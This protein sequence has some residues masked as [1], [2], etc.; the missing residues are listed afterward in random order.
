MSSL[1]YNGVDIGYLSTKE[2]VYED[3]M[4]EDG[5]D[6]LCTK[7]TIHVQGHLLADPASSIPAAT[8]WVNAQQLLEQPRCALLFQT[9]AV[10]IAADDTTDVKNGPFPQITSI[11]RIDGINAIHVGFTVVTYRCEVVPADGYISNR[12][13]DEETRDNQWL[14]RTKR[15]GTV[16]VLG[17]AGH[18]SPDDFRDA[19]TPPVAINFVR[20]RAVFALQSDGLAMTYTIEDREVMQTPPSPTVSA[21]GEFIETQTLPGAYRTGQANVRLLGSKITPTNAMILQAVSLAI[22]RLQSAGMNVVNGRFSAELSVKHRYMANG[23]DVSA[24]AMLRNYAKGLTANGSNSNYDHYSRLPW[25]TDNGLPDFPLRSEGSANSYAPPNSAS[26]P[27]FVQRLAQQVRGNVTPNA[28]AMANA[29]TYFVAR[30]ATIPT[31]ESLFISGGIYTHYEVRP[32]Y[33]SR[34]GIVELPGTADGADIAFCH[35]SQPTLRL[36]LEWAAERI[37]EPPAIPSSDLQADAGPVLLKSELMPGMIETMPGGAY[38][39][40]VA[41]SYEFGFKKPALV[42]MQAAVAPWAAD[43]E[44]ADGAIPIGDLFVNHA[45]RQALNDQVNTIF[46]VGD[47]TPIQAPAVAP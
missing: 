1:K 22:Q 42:K 4:S 38:R 24:R 18:T 13:R 30:V 25:P 45:A 3:Q 14:A 26:S 6:Y 36:V 44:R 12:W 20:E 23:V 27:A 32:R 21:D 2:V 11:N 31:D 15:T 19:V 39:Y 29:T 17:G 8:R 40:R 9:D 37:G 10:I 7:I 43:L 41:G 35:V 28:G 33:V 5:Q 46:S 47:A 34:P 16:I